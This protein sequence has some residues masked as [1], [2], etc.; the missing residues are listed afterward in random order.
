[1]Q[2]AVQDTDA[3]LD[4]RS[5]THGRFRDFSRTT[6]E[7]KAALRGGANWRNLNPVQRQALEA[8]ADKA[9]R[10]VNGDAY[11]FDHWADLAGYVQLAVDDINGRV[12]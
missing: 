2:K 11:F 6:Q 8:L 9:S 12:R 7:I 3:L 4:E 1:M 5:Q 10:I